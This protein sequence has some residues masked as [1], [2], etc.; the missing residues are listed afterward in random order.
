MA[1]PQRE[2]ARDLPTWELVVEHDDIIFGGWSDEKK[3]H[4]QP[5]RKRGILE[6]LSAIEILLKVGSLALS[7][8][9]LHA[10]GVPTDTILKGLANLVG[11]LGFL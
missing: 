1:Q 4:E 2:A 9:V 8:L 11:H 5:K 6:R 10:I 3:D 7:I